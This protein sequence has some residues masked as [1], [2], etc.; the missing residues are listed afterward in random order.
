MNLT[1]SKPSM[2]VFLAVL[3][4]SLSS[5]T[6]M[7]QSPVNKPVAARAADKV[8]LDTDIGDDID[9]AF[10]LSLALN[11]PELKIIGITSA[12]GNTAL[13]SRLLDRILCE[14]GREDVPVYT[15]VPT[16]TTTKFTQQ[17]WANQGIEHPH[18]DAVT[19]LL[20]QIRQNPGE[21]TLIAIAPL[22]NIG[23]AIERDPATFRKLK[24]VVLMG[25]SIYR[26]YDDF[27]YNTTHKP[28]AEYNIAMDVAASQKLFTSGV[29][30]YMMPLD[31]TQLKFDETKR[32]L[33]AS[34]STPLTDSLQV[35][36][37]EW[38]RNAQQTTP[39]M[40][41]VVATAYAIDPQTCPTT[42]LHIEVDDKGF[43]RI[44][45]GQPNANACLEPHTDA[46]FNLLMPRLLNQKMTGTQVCTEPAKN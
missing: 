34:I 22:T 32:S 9:D 1:N 18:S 36:T 44:A 29:P 4:M 33:L 43:T 5:K 28:E 27:A 6:S 45:P 3:S 10:A 8:I 14:T 30:I 12:W 19:F 7:A 38:Q 11:S 20:D 2:M 23:A 16:K 26:G 37:A 25:G 42:P 15:G 35:L 21:I 39:T 17:A 24:R 40:F 13:R 46:F 41:D 31:S